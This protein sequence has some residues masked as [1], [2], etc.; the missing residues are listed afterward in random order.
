M[1]DDQNSSDND[2]I[3]GIRG[4]SPLSREELQ[5][6][7]AALIRLEN[8]GVL[9]GAGASS[10]DLGGKT[11]NQL[12]A[13]FVQKYKDSTDW[14]KRYSFIE[15]G[16]TPN[17]EELL[18]SLE[19]ASIE[20]KRQKWSRRLQQLFFARDNILRSI[21]SSSLLKREWWKEPYLVDSTCKELT[22]HRVLLQR[23]TAS[24]QPGQPSPWVFTTNYDLAI[25]WAAE[26][27]GL[28]IINGFEGLH[29]RVFSPHSFDLGLRN[30]LAR[31]EARFGTYGIYLAKLH[32]SLSWRLTNDEV[33]YIELP[34]TSIFK[35]IDD[36]LNGH[37]SSLGNKYPIVYPS[38]AKYVQTAGFVLGEL[39][40]R[41]TEFLSR[42]Q[43]CIITLGYSFSD[44]HI[45]QFLARALQNPTLQIVICLPKIKYTNDKPVLT[46]CNK[47]IQE[48]CNLESPQ[49]TI[50]GDGEKAWLYNFVNYLPDP[51]IFDEQ[52]QKIRDL[53]KNLKNEHT[54][55][56]IQ[57]RENE[58]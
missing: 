36:F 53:L 6:H 52:A 30:M 20:W 22:N 16:Q 2:K 3:F 10:G 15:D 47:W 57:N 55:P 35:A 58:I 49:L 42:P 7:L 39:N 8:I 13:D 50:I 24:R 25:E 26:S 29:N 27:I 56:S 23:L 17:I 21:I 18:D 11:M 40:R 41:F 5:A 12:W 14:L 44:N 4:N 28:K 54:I 32:G 51:A 46:N 33:S 37:S 45:N 19:I 31:G 48:I 43:S 34:T 9:V 38:A 1:V